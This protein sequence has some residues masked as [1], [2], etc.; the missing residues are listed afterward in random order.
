MCRC[1]RVRACVHQVGCGCKFEHTRSL[2]HIVPELT[3]SLIAGNRRLRC[4]KGTT[5]WL[6][7]WNRFVASSFTLFPSFLQLP[8]CSFVFLLTLFP[9]CCFALSLALHSVVAPTA[10]LGR[11]LFVAR[12]YCSL[13]PF[14]Y[15]ATLCIFLSCSLG[16]P[17]TSLNTWTD[18]T[19]GKLCFVSGATARQICRQKQRGEPP[20][21]FSYVSLAGGGPRPRKK[22]R[23]GLRQWEVRGYVVC[24]HM[25]EMHIWHAHAQMFHACTSYARMHNYVMH[26]HL[27]LACTTMP[28][29]HK[30]AVDAHLT[31]ACTTMPCMHIWRSHA[32][33]CHACISLP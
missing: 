10:S 14:V 15:L 6:S 22:P 4:T 1:V 29:M 30:F 9:S 17:G 2:S 18:A 19:Q 7:S 8:S 21:R 32:Q 28:C 3:A 27:T 23:P 12:L 26:A 11:F 24:K 5:C 31:R 33:L 13:P 20:R 25:P 16:S